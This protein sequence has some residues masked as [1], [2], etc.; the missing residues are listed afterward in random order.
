MTYLAQATRP[1]ISYAVHAVSQFSSNP[2]RRHWEA[3]KRIFRCLKSTTPNSLRYTKDGHSEV[4]GY[5]DADWGGD[6][7]TRKSTAGYVFMLQNGAI[8]WN[9]KKQPTVALSSCEA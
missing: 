1:D 9:V 8:S 5:T 3:V 7:D 2:G 4:I 6:A